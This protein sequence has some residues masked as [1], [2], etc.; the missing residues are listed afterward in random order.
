MKTAGRSL[1]SLQAA[2]AVRMRSQVL[3]QKAEV[4]VTTAPRTYKGTTENGRILQRDHQHLLAT[5]D[6]FN[7]KSSGES[8]VHGNRNAEKSDVS[9]QR[10]SHGVWVAELTLNNAFSNVFR[11][12]P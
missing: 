8:D 11:Y 2:Q 7:Q 9:E 3:A 4:I 5:S 1:Y 10:L 12:H 6:A